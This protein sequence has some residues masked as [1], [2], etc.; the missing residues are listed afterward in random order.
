MSAWNAIRRRPVDG[1]DLQETEREEVLAMGYEPPHGYWATVLLANDFIPQLEDCLL[2]NRGMEKQ[3]IYRSK[4]EVIEEK[5]VL[6]Q[7]ACL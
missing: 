7:F 3:R 5:W 4:T 1:M 6:L 2:Q